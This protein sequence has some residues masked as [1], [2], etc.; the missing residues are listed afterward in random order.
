MKES[1]Y[2]FLVLAVIALAAGFINAQTS[3]WIYLGLPVGTILFGL[4]LVTRVL[5]K[6]WALYDEQNRAPV[7]A[8]QPG[9]VASQQSK[10]IPQE[11]AHHPAL[12]TA[13]PH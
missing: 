13:S 9:S 7:Y 3:F 10:I 2:S 11:V 12:T 1:K 4:F 6:E 8:H 5:E